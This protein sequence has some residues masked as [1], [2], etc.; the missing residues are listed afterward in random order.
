MLNF[1]EP[2]NWFKK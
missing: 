1:F 2:V